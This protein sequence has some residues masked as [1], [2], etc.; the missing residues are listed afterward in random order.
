M[1]G[2]LGIALFIV[3]VTQIVS[4]M[5]EILDLLGTDSPFYQPVLGCGIAVAYLV[6]AAQAATSIVSIWAV[7]PKAKKSQLK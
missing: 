4:A 6:V 2:V 7:S 3:S 1:V 5:K